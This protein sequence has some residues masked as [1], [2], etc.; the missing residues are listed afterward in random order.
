MSAPYPAYAR[1]GA[2]L[3]LPSNQA[4]K[5]LAMAPTKSTLNE[6]HV[7][8]E[9]ALYSSLCLLEAPTG[10]GAKLVELSKTMFR[11]Q[12]LKSFEYIIYHCYTVVKGKAAA[13]KVRDSL[14]TAVHCSLTP[15][16]T[17]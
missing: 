17:Q 8:E 1:A 10:E 5:L 11:K 12:N 7:Q 6:H 4:L 2:G 13:K 14:H 16:C 15:Q 3:T 9:L